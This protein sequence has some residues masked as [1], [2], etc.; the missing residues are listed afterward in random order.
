[1]KL[2]N[3]QTENFRVTVENG[4]ATVKAITPMAKAYLR[5][6]KLENP[7]AAGDATDTDTLFRFL[8]SLESSTAKLA[9][10]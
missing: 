8:A 4:K 9:A 1:M 5:L 6:K 10:I 2:V 7:L 3:L